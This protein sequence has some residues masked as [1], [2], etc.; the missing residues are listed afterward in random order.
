MKIIEAIRKRRSIRRFKRKDVRPEAIKVILDAGR[1]AP[2]ASN[3]QPLRFL[4]LSNEE[5]RKPAAKLYVDAYKKE[6]EDIVLREDAD[7]YF[8][9]PYEVKK[10][11]L[12]MLDLLESQLKDPAFVIVICA[13]TRISKSYLFEAGCAVQNMMLAAWELRL[14]TCCIEI[15]T[16]LLS[17]YFDKET[18]KRIYNIP[19][20]VEVVAMM[21]IGRIEEIPHAPERDI[22]KEFTYTGYWF[23][24]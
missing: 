5:E 21:P 12:N 8:E 20:H 11:I 24:E 10:R 16:T 9:N 3:K 19:D 18:L 6:A 15:M 22:L 17:E 1:W 13:D 2:S 23:G 14:G 7:A 4:I